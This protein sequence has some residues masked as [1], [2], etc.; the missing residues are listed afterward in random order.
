[1]I[2]YQNGLRT[3]QAFEDKKLIVTVLLS[4]VIGGVFWHLL[5]CNLSSTWDI[6]TTVI[7]NMLFIYPVIEE[8]VFR[9]TIQEGLL[10]NKSLRK[11]YYGVSNANLIASC[12][13]MGFHMI[14]QP[15]LFAVLVFIPSVVF[16]FFK[17]RYSA[18][19]VPIGL[20]IL[21]N[22]IFLLALSNK[23]C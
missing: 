22:G 20:H 21:F 15:L 19:L 5:P 4:I 16:G 3:I 2:T 14:H 18:L 7:I 10:K 12:L 23:L 13:F 1:M 17:E 6:S 11:A 8:W 9:G